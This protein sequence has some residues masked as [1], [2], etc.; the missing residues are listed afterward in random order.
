MAETVKA[1]TQMNILNMNQDQDASR[2]YNI[3]LSLAKQ[4]KQQLQQHENIHLMLGKSAGNITQAVEKQAS[5]DEKTFNEAKA[6]MRPYIYMLSQNKDADRMSD[7]EYKSLL[8]DPSITNN[9]SISVSNFLKNKPTITNRI[10]KTAATTINNLTAKYTGFVQNT[11]A[12]TNTLSGGERKTTDEL[13]ATTNLTPNIYTGN[14]SNSSADRAQALRQNRADYDSN[15]WALSGTKA[16]DVVDTR[17]QQLLSTKRSNDPSETEIREYATAALQAQA[18]GNTQEFIDYVE[19]L[20]QSTVSRNTTF[21]TKFATLKKQLAQILPQM[22]QQL[23]QGSTMKEDLESNQLNQAE[24]SKYVNLLLTNA[25]NPVQV[26]DWST[27]D[28]DVASADDVSTQIPQEYRLAAKSQ[29]FKI[30]I[31]HVKNDP[32]FM[33]TIEHGY[34]PWIPLSIYDKLRNTV[35]ELDALHQ[36]LVADEHKKKMLRHAN[37]K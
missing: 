6:V 9:K 11:N 19:L 37:I 12:I 33:D 23:I 1:L 29:A 10:A 24:L 22:K 34:I 35:E 26:D 21:N 30:L 16:I 32:D 28:P 20:T 36:Q 5:I 17:L 18:A 4:S 13:G 2:G 31:N 3:L 15:L 25:S 14:I 8:A 27:Y 7:A